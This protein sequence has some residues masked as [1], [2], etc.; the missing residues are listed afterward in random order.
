MQMTLVESTVDRGPNAPVG[1]TSRRDHQYRVVERSHV[2]D[3][4]TARTR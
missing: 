1:T 4:G 3:I 2:R